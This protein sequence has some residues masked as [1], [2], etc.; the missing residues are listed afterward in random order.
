MV[1]DHFLYQK[2][3][4]ATQCVLCKKET[5][6]QH[7]DTI[8]SRACTECNQVFHKSCIPD[9]H[10]PDYFPHHDWFCHRCTKVRKTPEGLVVMNITSTREAIKRHNTNAAAAHQEETK[11]RMQHLI[12]LQATCP[13]TE[14]IE[15]TSN[16]D[17]IRTIEK[18][19]LF[20]GPWLKGDTLDNRTP[21][22]IT[23][24]KFTKGIPKTHGP[25]KTDQTGMLDTA[26]YTYLAEINATAPPPENVQENE[27]LRKAKEWNTHTQLS[28]QPGGNTNP[29][30]TWTTT[31]THPPPSPPNTRERPSKRRKGQRPNSDPANKQPPITKPNTGANGPHSQLTRDHAQQ[32]RYTKSNTL[33]MR[34]RHASRPRNVS[35]HLYTGNDQEE[36]KR[37]NEEF[38]GHQPNSSAYRSLLQHRNH[39]TETMKVDKILTTKA[40]N[41]NLTTVKVIGDGNCLQYATNAAHKEQ[42]NLY[43]ANNDD[44]RLLATALARE[45]T[46]Q[47]IEKATDDIRGIME[48]ELKE[49]ELTATNSYYHYPGT[50]MNALASIRHGPLI[51]LTDIPEMGPVT[52]LPLKEMTEILFGTNTMNSAPKRH[53]SHRSTS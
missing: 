6:Q 27:L 16:N 41:L 35:E 50:Y 49:I 36:L 32:I 37:M 3:E 19:K 21:A 29:E 23:V 45:Y 26:R 46:L 33:L 44:L 18:Q 47:Q 14:L 51:V 40:Q 17:M 53:S 25:G 13:T 1:L 8:N 39:L 4:P 11:K 22:T 2:P 42:T 52:Y 15:I 12:D 38:S 24:W 31:T 48:G 10:K 7:K 28:T 30:P 43:L 20:N 34:F 9:E 5:P